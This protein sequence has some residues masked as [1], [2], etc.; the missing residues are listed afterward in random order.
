MLSFVNF[1]R[2]KVALVEGKTPSIDALIRMPLVETCVFDLLLFFYL[3]ANVKVSLCHFV[4]KYYSLASPGNGGFLVLLIQF[5]FIWCQV[6]GFRF[7]GV[8]K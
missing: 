5:A 4:S 8:A 3:H 7:F 1:L 2:R 6:S